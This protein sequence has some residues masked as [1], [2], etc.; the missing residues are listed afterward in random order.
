ML[1]TYEKK[2]L[3]F[4]VGIII[5]GT[6]LFGSEFLSMKTLLIMANQLPEYGLISIALMITLIVAGMNLSIVSMTTLAGIIGALTMHYFEGLGSFSVVIGIIVMLSVG[7]LTGAINGA[8]VSFL[9]VSPIVT[10][11]GTMMLFKG[12][13]LNITQGGAIR[14]FHPFF[15]YIGNGKIL[16]MP[17]PLFVFIVVAIIVGWIL[18]SSDFGKQLYRIGKNKEAAIY[19]GINVKKV[20]FMAYILAG[21]VAGITAMVMTARYNSIRVDYG[22]AYLLNGLVIVSLGG[23]DINGGKGTMKGMLIA[24]TIISVMLRILNLAYMDSH[25]MSAIMGVILLVNIFIQHYSNQRM[26]RKIEKEI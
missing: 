16:G 19:S 25:L 17:F 4:L 5:L 21:I 14:S 3:G 6:A 11:L 8:V 18:S 1:N 20:I 12:V 10:T 26:K 9:E 2:L 22:E 23:I 24:V 15:T 7:A 13:A